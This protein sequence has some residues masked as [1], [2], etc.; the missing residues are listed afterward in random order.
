MGAKRA[1]RVRLGKDRSAQQS[2][3]TVAIAQYAYR[4]S[5]ALIEAPAIARLLLV[6]HTVRVFR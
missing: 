4:P 1:Y 5:R 6:E 3:H 2:G